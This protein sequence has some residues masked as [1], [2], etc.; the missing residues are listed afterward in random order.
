[1]GRGRSVR[2]H[3]IAAML[4]IAASQSPCQTDGLLPGACRGNPATA[5][6]GPLFSPC[7]LEVPAP[8][9]FRPPT[10]RLE[11]K[12]F[13]RMQYCYY[14]QGVDKR[15]I[16][17]WLEQIILEALHVSTGLFRQKSVFC[18]NPRRV[19]LDACTPFGLQARPYGPPVGSVF[20]AHLTALGVRA[21]QL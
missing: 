18:R 15:S 21:F 8:L 6:N 19:A 7:G 4:H 17:Y 14:G 11:G 3:G 5:R 2:R 16:M 10:S 12:C 13:F 1:M 9:P 20:A